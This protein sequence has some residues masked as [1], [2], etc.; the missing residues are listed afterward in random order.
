MKDLVLILAFFYS[1]ARMHGVR[2]PDTFVVIEYAKLGTDTLGR[3]DR[4]A[5]GWKIKISTDIEPELVETIVYH[6]M[7]HVLGLPDCRCNTLM[8]YANILPLTDRMRR[9]FYNQLKKNNELSL[10]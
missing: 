8:N 9:Q 1:D 6:E 7:G 3:T 4:F 5:G 10:Q 2:L